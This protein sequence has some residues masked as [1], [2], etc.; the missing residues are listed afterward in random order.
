ME[1]GWDQ[2][3]SEVMYRL[4][5]IDTQLSTMHCQLDD[6]SKQITILKAKAGVIAAIVGVAVSIAVTVLGKYLP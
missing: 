5:R 2:R 6:I 1:N 4:E 3:K